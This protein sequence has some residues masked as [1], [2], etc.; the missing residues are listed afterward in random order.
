MIFKEID[1][2]KNFILILIFYEII[3]L[4]SSSSILLLSSFVTTLPFDPIIFF[5]GINKWMRWTRNENDKKYVYNSKNLSKS[6][7]SLPF[8]SFT[9]ISSSDHG[10]D[11]KMNEINIINSMSIHVFAWKREKSLRRLCNSLLMANYYGHVV[12]LY[13]YVDGG[14]LDLV[15]SYIKSFQWPHGKKYMNF[16]DKFMGLPKVINFYSFLFSINSFSFKM[17]YHQMLFFFSFPFYSFPK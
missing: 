10:N 6:S 7:V 8:Q 3:T 2:L 12:D 17:L 1:H 5:D 16:K 11:G 13:F 4:S 15:N 14:S 9:L